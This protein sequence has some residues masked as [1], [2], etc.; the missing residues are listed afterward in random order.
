MKIQSFY[1]VVPGDIDLWMLK[2]Q[3]LGQY[4]QFQDI[5]SKASQISLDSVFGT[6]RKWHLESF[7]ILIN[8][9]SKCIGI[10][11]VISKFIRAT[12][13][14]VHISVKYRDKQNFWS[15]ETNLGPSTGSVYES[16]VP[17]INCLLRDRPFYLK[18]GRLWFFVSFRIFF[19]DNTRVRIFFF[20]SRIKKT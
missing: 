2:L 13:S 17:K 5:A 15:P 3:R 4:L 8:F 10:M 12:W 14:T 19:S 16:I 20:W 11:N 18:V 1:S 7:W 9:G 6:L